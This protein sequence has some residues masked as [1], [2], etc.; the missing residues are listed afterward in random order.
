MIN[1][2]VPTLMYQ[3][4]KS[5]LTI[6]GALCVPPQQDPLPFPPYN[7]PILSYNLLVFLDNFNTYLFNAKQYI[8]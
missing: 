5:T 1:P 6:T 3:L 2:H 8:A 4:K 7:N